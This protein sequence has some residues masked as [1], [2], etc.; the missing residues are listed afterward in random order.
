[1]P[2]QPDDHD[3]PPFLRDGDGLRI[4]EL[5]IDGDEP[6]EIDWGTPKTIAPEVM[7]EAREKMT[8]DAISKNL[9]EVAQDP[10]L[11]AQMSRQN[12]ELLNTQL[13]MYQ[14]FMA[15]P[16]KLRA[17]YRREIG[18]VV[19]DLTRD[20]KYGPGEIDG[21]K[22]LYLCVVLLGDQDDDDDGKDEE[23]SVPPSDGSSTPVLA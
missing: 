14:R 20:M 3:R 15:L 23:P 7:R 1:M 18:A 21:D 8:P 9:Q 2:D 22:R 12:S 11:L 10:D 16:S 5:V 19:R 6:I 17:H 13:E 4:D